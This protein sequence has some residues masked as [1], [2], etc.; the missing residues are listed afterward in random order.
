MHILE[1]LLSI[2]PSVRPNFFVITCIAPAKERSQ[3]VLKKQAQSRQS[4]NTNTTQEEDI[5][6]M[7][8]D[9]SDASIT[10]STLRNE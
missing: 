3:K 5:T 10:G 8:G 6:I 2:L 1:K 4:M 9:T 7:A